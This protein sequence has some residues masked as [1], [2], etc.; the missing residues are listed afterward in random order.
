MAGGHPY[1]L[2][3]AMT[4]AVACRM[5]AEPPPPEPPTPEPWHWVGADGR[6]VIHRG[7]N[8]NNAAKDTPDHNHDLTPADLALLPAHGF[9]LVRLLVFW[10]AIEPT[11][12][13]YDDAYLAQVRADVEALEALD[14]EVV[15]DLHQDVYGEG[16]GFTGFP[17]WT[18]DE[19]AYA[20]F[21]PETGLWF[22]NYFDPNV[23]GCFD[24]FW[25][26]EPLQDA[27][28]AMV[29]RLAAEV[30]DLDAV[31]GIDVM[32]E[33]FYGSTTWL[34]HDE[35]VLPA[36]YNRV[37]AA[38]RAEHPTVRL[39]LAPSVAAN[40]FAMPALDLS[41]IDDPHLAVTPHFYPPYAELGT[42]FD[43]DF[44]EE[45]ANLG[46]LAA[47]AR[48]QGVPFLL[49]EFGIF[50]STGTEP[51][52]IG[53]VL[54]SVEAEGGSSAYWSYDRGSGLLEGEGEAGWLLDT[55]SGPWAHRIPGRLVASEGASVEFE[56]VG[57]GM[58]DFVVPAG[59]DCSASVD[60][61]VLLSEEMADNRLVLHVEGE[62][63]V[64]AAVSCP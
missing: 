10:E 37:A 44:S 22:L 52:F 45:A 50:S 58:I 12:G 1:L 23:I 34:E 3:T 18:C 2:A 19:A 35:Q 36:F 26:S 39:F 28:A 64:R 27:Y 48:D 32:N 62:G 53:S 61:G 54:A 14:L 9:T 20:A 33:P 11:E 49:G 46:R 4:L 63:A 51:D 17:R 5:P 6:T 60:P 24:A 40:V 59:T 41:G 31:V 16:F 56:L 29:A 57:E 25:G 43:G 7:V 15:L 8:L 13:S 21:T 30:A 47:H 38:V 55:W 42:G